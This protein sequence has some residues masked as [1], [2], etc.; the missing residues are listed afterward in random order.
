MNLGD[1]FFVFLFIW[2]CFTEFDGVSNIFLG[3]LMNF[4]GR[5]MYI[6]G[7]IHTVGGGGF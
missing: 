6:W 7:V 3:I 1:E 5:L 2:G 4:E